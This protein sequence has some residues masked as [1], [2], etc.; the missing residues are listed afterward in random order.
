MVINTN[1][2]ST[3]AANQVKEAQSMLVNS[4]A[5]LASGFKIVQP[6]DDAGGLAAAINLANQRTRTGAAKSNLTSM[7]SLIH[8]QDG[9]LKTI[10][11]TLQRMGDLAVLYKDATK[12]AADRALYN[13]EFE[14]LN[15]VID[16]LQVRRF[17]GKRLFN[18]TSPNQVTGA[19]TEITTLTQLQVKIV[20]EQVYGF[21][22]GTDGQTTAPVGMDDV[23]A[24]AGGRKHSLALASDGSVTVWGDNSYGQLTVPASLPEA[25]K[26]VAGDYYSAALTGAGG[27]VAWGLNDFGQCTIPAGLSNVTDISAG[28]GHMLALKSDGTVVAWGDNTS[29]QSSIP[30]GLSNVTAIAGGGSHSLALKSDGTVVAWGSNTQGQTSVPAGLTGV[31]AISAGFEHSTALKSDGTVVQWGRNNGA[32]PGSA[33]GITQIADGYY[34]SLALKSDG[35]AIAWGNNFDGRTTI[36]AGATDVTTIDA[37]ATFSLAVNRVKLHIND[38]AGVLS[39]T[40]SVATA[41]A[42]AGANLTRVEA[43]IDEATIIE[44]NTSAAV[45]RITDVD[46]AQEMTRYAR[47]QILT[48]SGSLLLA[49]SNSLPSAALR[50]LLDNLRRN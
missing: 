34:H 13:E 9:V 39:A 17:N 7:A 41:E 42:N 43:E 40:E 23:T 24:V 38:L 27:V 49:K 20:Y 33:T 21:G 25:R 47:Y 26:I 45:S 31:I 11:K 18:E 46:V 44:E 16:E 5:R 10:S 36:P 29:G 28:N 48:N 8:T 37:G 30:G 6:Q 19:S 1:T 3:R 32:I 12:T 22:I 14:Q 4:L 2:T 50:V 35:T 15:N